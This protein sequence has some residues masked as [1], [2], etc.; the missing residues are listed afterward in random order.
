MFSAESGTVTIFHYD[1]R[2]LALLGSLNIPNAHTVA[3]D[4]QTHLVY[5]HLENINGR[6]VL[7]IMRPD[8]QK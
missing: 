1:N 2:R 5:F 8:G 3:V 6:P 7:R 4:P